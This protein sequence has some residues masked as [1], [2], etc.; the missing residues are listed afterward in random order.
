MLL[1]RP[2]PSDVNVFPLHNSVPTSAHSRAIHERFAT[3]RAGDFQSVSCSR[4][5]GQTFPSPSPN[6]ELNDESYP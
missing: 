1:S 6:A 5:S 2:I 3:F 4:I